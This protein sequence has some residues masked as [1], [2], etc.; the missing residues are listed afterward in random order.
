VNE[1]QSQLASLFKESVSTACGDPTRAQ[2]ALFP[3]EE[4]LVSDASPSRRLEFLEGRAC[5]HAALRKLGYDEAPILRGKDRQPRWPS[6]F[7]GSISHTDSFC[8]VAVARETDCAGLGLDVETDLPV[9]EDFAR[10][11]CSE[12]ELLRCAQHGSSAQLARVVF[13]AKESVYKLQHPLSGIV[14][15]WRDLEVLLGDGH[16]TARF[17]TA[18]PPFQIGQELV[19]RWCRSRG[20]CE[21]LQRPGLIFTGL[22]LAVPPSKLCKTPARYGVDSC[23]HE[24][25]E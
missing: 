18:C 15:Y 13:S 12:R 8:A 10:R 6:G 21:S 9:S 7:V 11:V 2:S 4:A 19:G 1:R 20:S 22:E 3:E 23:A 24:G 17:L 14:L 5:A 16:F 25:P